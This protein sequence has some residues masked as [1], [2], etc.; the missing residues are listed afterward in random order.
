MFSLVTLSLCVLYEY[1]YVSN[2]GIALVA[3]YH[4]ITIESGILF[5]II[6]LTR[7]YCM[8]LEVLI[9]YITKIK[10]K[11]LRTLAF[12]NITVNE[13]MTTKKVVLIE[14]TGLASYWLTQGNTLFD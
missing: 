3:L 11:L 6:V 5:N 2:V 12:N 4:G 9:K 14:Y 7:F 10:D 1:D 8:S 13:S